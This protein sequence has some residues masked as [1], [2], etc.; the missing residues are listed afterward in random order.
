MDEYG[1][2]QDW[3][4]RT[5]GGGVGGGT[6]GG[7][8]TGVVGGVVGGVGVG[9][10]SGLM[11]KKRVVYGSTELLNAE[12]FLLGDLMKLGKESR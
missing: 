2:L 11:T 12:E 3:A 7:G 8:V 6:V 9:G 10:G 1:N 4:K 5:S